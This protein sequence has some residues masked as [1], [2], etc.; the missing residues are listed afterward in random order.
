MTQFEKDLLNACKVD[1]PKGA[2]LDINGNK[3]PTAIYNLIVSRRDVALYSKGIIPHRGWKITPVKE[4]FGLK[5]RP[6]KC[7]EQI[8]ALL[9]EYYG[10]PEA[11]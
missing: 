5:G 10:R 2:Y 4:Y 11:E 1:S 7:L 3:M 8:E 9:E 6:E